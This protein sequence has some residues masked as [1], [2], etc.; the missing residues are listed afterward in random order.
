[1]N[2]RVD[3]VAETVVCIQRIDCLGNPSADHTLV[4]SSLANLVL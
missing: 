3:L 2:F 1:M 4:Y